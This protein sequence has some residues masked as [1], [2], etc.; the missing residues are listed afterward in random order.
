MPAFARR[1]VALTLAVATIATSSF[2]FRVSAVEASTAPSS[3]KLISVFFDDAITG[4][5]IAEFATQ[6]SLTIVQPV[7]D[8]LP[9]ATFQS[10]DREAVLPLLR[11]DTRVR[12]ASRVEPKRATT[13]DP[14][15][16][17]QWW[18]ANSGQSFILGVAWSILRATGVGEFIERFAGIAGK[19][20]KWL[21]AMAI[22]AC[23]GSA[24]TGRGV[25]VAV[26]DSGID[27][28]H[29]DLAGQLSPAS[30]SAVAGYGPADDE[31]GHGTFIGGLIAA[32]GDNGV[33]LTGVAPDS[34]LLSV[35]VSLYG[36][37]VGN[38]AEAIAY[39]GDAGA[40]VINLSYGSEEIDD[41]ERMI[42]AL[43]TAPPYNAIVV[44]SA[45]NGG[46][47]GN[48]VLY[49]AAYPHVISVGA[50]DSEGQIAAFSQINGHVDVS[51]PGMMVFSTFANT[52]SDT[53]CTST[54]RPH[55]TSRYVLA[56]LDKY[57]CLFFDGVRQ[58]TLYK[59]GSG[60]S[61]AAPIVAGAA[62]LAKQKWPTL[63]GDQFEGLV[64]A[65]ADD[66]A[67]G[68]GYDPEY[69]AGTLN[70]HRLLSYNFPP[71]IDAAHV[72]FTSPV[73][74][75]SG[76]DTT[77]IVAQ[78]G[79]LEGMA[80]VTAVTAD[81]SAIGVAEPVTLAPDGDLVYRSVPQTISASV[82]EGQYTVAVIVRDAAGATATA[83]APLQ[84][85][86]A[87]S[88]IPSLPGGGANVAP[89]QSTPDLALAITSPKAG[90]KVVT[91]KKAITL[92]GT[93]GSGVAAVEVNGE[94]AAVDIAA[95]TWTHKA[96]LKSGKNRIEVVTFDVTRSF[97]ED[98]TVEVVLDR[99]APG[100][101]KN[102][103]ASSG[104]KEIELTWEAPTDRDVAGYH[105]YA[106]EGGKW[107]EVGT[108]RKT[109]ATV[110]ATGTLV[111]IAEDEAGNEGDFGTA[112]RAGAGSISFLDV[113][114]GHFAAP[115]VSAL[116]SR[117]VIQ[118]GDRFR[119][120]D[121]ITRAEFAKL[122]ILARGESGTAVN[123]GQ[124][125]DVPPSYSLAD[126]IGTAV[127]LR[128]ASGQGNQF[129][130]NRAITRI[131]AARMLTHALGL[132]P[133]DQPLFG[134]VTDAGERRIAAAIA[135][136]G[137]A[138]GQGDRFMPHRSLTRAEAA[139]MVAKTL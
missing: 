14:L 7:G 4:L 47:Q 97:H 78:V 133:A 87:G 109:R 84:V 124:F 73:V 96:A 103:R 31:N 81:L 19:D 127:R 89:V 99:T 70:I 119:P 23:G 110:S 137:I 37:Y 111:I 51:A 36:D 139:K 12:A 5:Q 48:P 90:R 26:I 128:W 105:I 118:R 131:E 134:D 100:P 71:T 123:A 108:S 64:R 107:K 113:A 24:C 114:S 55:Y 6:Y 79:N 18:L 132:E 77:S 25:T 49:P 52:I 41:V 63:N 135:K 85:L 68:N 93:I 136:A 94:S 69:G 43:A 75:N 88:A 95:K 44:A 82:P 60:T 112:P 10:E 59:S 34:K 117:G 66:D 86:T 11:R 67:S 9:I 13:N 16:N 38:T 40:Q 92:S 76:T 74:T 17:D 121:A 80:D 39:A 57:D 28:S 104:G 130:P 126:F 116:L 21:S 3:P 32:R 98:T 54:G 8:D 15:Y 53:D 62:A 83:S 33:G 20:T 30:A 102:L 138:T 91:R 65:T 1:L 129:F 46:D 56:Y 50:V 2:D 61:Y 120:D 22:P 101:V 35:K 115:A 42:I 29:L 27:G 58:D 72:G 125:M 45:G 106:D 122:L